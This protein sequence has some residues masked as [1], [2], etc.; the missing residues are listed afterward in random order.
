MDTE[1]PKDDCSGVGG[2]GKVEA[3]DTERGSGERCPYGVYGTVP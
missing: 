2:G 3:D 1:E